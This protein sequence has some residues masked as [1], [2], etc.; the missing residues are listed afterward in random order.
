MSSFQYF[1]FK[2]GSSP[3]K[4][5]SGLGIICN[6]GMSVNTRSSSDCLHKLLD[7]L[8]DILGGCERILKT[9]MP[10]LYTITSRRCSFISYYCL[11]LVVVL[12][13][14]TGPLL[15]FISFIHLVLMKWG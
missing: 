5:P 7:E 2:N 12:A 1:N 11:A 6:V 13:W 9:P 8:V 3:L 14:W 15:A 10:L 4:L